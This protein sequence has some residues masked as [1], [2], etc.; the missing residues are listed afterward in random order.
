MDDIFGVQVGESRWDLHDDVDDL[1]KLKIF[2]IERFEITV[3]LDRKS[4]V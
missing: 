2:V 1:G 3:V 4:V